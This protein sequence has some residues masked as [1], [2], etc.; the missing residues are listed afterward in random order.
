MWSAGGVVSKADR[1]PSITVNAVLRLSLIVVLYVFYYA[2]IRLIGFDITVCKSLQALTKNHALHHASSC[3][4]TRKLRTNYRTRPACTGLT[5]GMGS[6]QPYIVASPI[7]L[8][9]DRRFCRMIELCRRRRLQLASS[10]VDVRHTVKEG[11][12]KDTIVLNC[13][14]IDKSP[15]RPLRYTAYTK[16]AYNKL[17][18]SFCTSLQPKFAT[19]HSN[20]F[21]HFHSI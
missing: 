20:D 2:Q 10:A 8:C 7:V 12:P 3:T 13:T 6:A 14:A 11:F 21:R 4:R 19:T 17:T 9:F 1:A 15:S 16:R 18:S 5:E